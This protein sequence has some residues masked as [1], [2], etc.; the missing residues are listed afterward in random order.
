MF[1]VCHGGVFG[2]LWLGTGR[3]HILPFS[4]R[5]LYHEI[6]KENG[7][8]LRVQRVLCFIYGNQGGVAR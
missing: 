8:L 1:M 3:V 7:F 4:A 2:T 5:F 6:A